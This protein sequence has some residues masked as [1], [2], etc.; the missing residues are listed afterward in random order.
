MSDWD[1]PE[2]Q[3]LEDFAWDR[4][5]VGDLRGA[6][7]A[8]LRAIKL[9]PDTIDSY[10]ILAQAAAVLG[11]K[12]AYAR[13]AVRL[14]EIEFKDEIA[15][16]PSEDFPFWSVTRTRPYMRG[17]HTLALALWENGRSR[18]RDEAIEIAQKMLRICP[19]DNIGVRFLLPEWYARQS[20]WSLGRRLLSEFRDE[21]RTEMNMWAALYAFQDDDLDVAQDMVTKARQTNTH[22]VGQLLLKRHPKRSEAAWV[23]QGSIEEAKAYSNQA[24]DLW[25]SMN[26]GVEWLSQFPRR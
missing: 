21:Y 13:E 9:E 20:K 18:A 17:L 10:V 8:A 15:S 1:I 14:G 26:G 7:D 24:Y 6:T 2:Y 22:I 16:A 11:Q 3:E 19:N 4:M 23:A 25:R 12:Q 5:E